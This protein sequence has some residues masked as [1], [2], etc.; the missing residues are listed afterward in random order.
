M[1]TLDPNFFQQFHYTEAQIAQFFANAQKDFR[2]ATEVGEPNIAT[3]LY[4]D[5][6]IKIGI[7]HIARSGYK[8]RSIQG[9]HIK[10]L[11]AL[12]NIT[13]LEDEC[14]YMNRVRRDRNKDLYEGG[15]SFTQSHAE[16]LGRVVSKIF[17][18]LP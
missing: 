9:H 12:E 1:T 10:I 6:V 18:T 13:Q 5:A 15:V 16:N 3:R 11:E 2:L 17:R 8:I 14:A 7:A 4:Y